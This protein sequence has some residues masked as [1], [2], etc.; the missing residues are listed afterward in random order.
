[1]QEQ[2]EPIAF[3]DT[4]VLLDIFS[5]HDLA[6]HYDRCGADAAA[7][8]RAAI[9]RRARAR[10][11]L[12]LAIYL[13]QRRARTVSLRSEPME[14]LQQRVPSSEGDKFETHFT[15]LFVQFVFPTI[16]SGWDVSVMDCDDDCAA[17]KADALLVDSARESGLPVVS[18][19]GH[20]P[21]GYAPKFLNKYAMEQGVHVTTPREFL[22]PDFDVA[23]A[24]AWFLER[25]E[26]EA[27]RYLSSCENQ[28]ILRD[29]WR[30]MLGYFRHTLR[31]ETA[32][33]DELL[34]VE[35][36]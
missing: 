6:G 20:S 1:M 18:N 29:S 10:E 27:P 17:S 14:I 12:V 30:W 2:L 33:S 16:L 25:V 36:L 11:G 19:E 34:A 35:L 21:T 9:Y 28:E 15:V 26:V 7:S 31:G 3:V 5:C 23:E 32:G 8:D 4:N 24:T 13:H 22:P